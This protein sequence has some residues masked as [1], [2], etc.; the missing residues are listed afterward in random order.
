MDKTIT[1]IGAGLAGLSSACLLAK[2]GYKVRILDKHNSPGG[3]ARSEMEQGFQFDLGPTW[4]LMPEV[5]DDF[6]G[7]F[8]KKSSDYFELSHLD[9]SYRIFFEEGGSMDIHPD[10]EKNM[11]SFDKLEPQGGEKLKR[12]LENSA[13]KYK[14][15][16]GEFL[17]R[18]YRKMGDLM[19]WPLIKQGLKLNIFSNLHRF[20]K[21]YFKDSRSQKVV[22]FNTVFLGSSPYQVPALYSLMAHADLTEGVYFPKGGIIQLVLALESLAKELGVVIDYGQ[23]VKSIVIEGGLARGVETEKERIE[24]SAV[25]SSADYQHTEQ[26]LIEKPYRNYKARYWK[27]RT[28][29]PGVMLIFLGLNKKL[30][31]LA[32]HNFYFAEHWKTHFDSIFKKPSWPGNPSYYVGVPSVTDPQCAPEGSENLFVLVPVAPDMEDSDAIRESFSQQILDHLEKTIGEK[33][34]DSITVKKIISHREFKEGNLY[35]GTALGLSHTLFQSALFRPDHHSKKVSNLYYTGHYTQPGI[36]MPMA[37][38]GSRLVCDYIIKEW[39]RE[40]E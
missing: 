19:K 16:V 36:G 12:F 17:Y 25:L 28:M 5:F 23:E 38:I 1:I 24:C 15:A 35:Q 9:P 10:L 32:H 21:R 6:F 40:A 3:V 20:V 2:E 7:L 4:Y 8:G 14:I 39:P 11:Q 27:K 29:A 33:F 31:Q 13:M 37:M 30:P 22:E 26:E 18:D 34:Q